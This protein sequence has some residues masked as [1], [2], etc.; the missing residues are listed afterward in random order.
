MNVTKSESN[1]KT[2]KKKHCENCGIELDEDEVYE[3]DGMIL[4]GDCYNEEEDLRAIEE[5]WIE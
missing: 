3:I 2:K 1:T 5:E 4:C